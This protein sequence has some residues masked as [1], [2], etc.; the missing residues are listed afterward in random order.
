M[1]AHSSRP[2]VWVDLCVEETQMG[3]RKR[4]LLINLNTQTG[5]RSFCTVAAGRRGDAY[6]YQQLAEGVGRARANMDRVAK[7]LI[8]L[9]QHSLRNQS[10]PI[11]DVG[12]AQPCYEDQNIFSFSKN[13]F[14][15]WLS[16]R[17]NSR[18]DEKGGVYARTTGL[19]GVAC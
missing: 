8:A 1:R 13:F 14:E 6:Q 15:S 16:H 10:V 5:Q 12:L 17:C 3:K 9:V 7:S 18:R 11:Y 19:L 2:D 4:R